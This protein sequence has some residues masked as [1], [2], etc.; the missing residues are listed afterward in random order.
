MFIEVPRPVQHG[1]LAE[2]LFTYET[3][4]SVMAVHAYKQGLCS[5]YPGQSRMESWQIDLFISNGCA[6]HAYKDY[7]CFQ[8]PFQVYMGSEQKGCR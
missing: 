2:R 3:C 5:Q 1:M 4:L 7:S 8:Y 6:V